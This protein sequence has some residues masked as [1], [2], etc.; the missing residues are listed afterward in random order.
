V[1]AD[2]L[3]RRILE[4]GEEMVGS[5][6]W[7]GGAGRLMPDT[8]QINLR[9]QW[10]HDNDFARWIRG[11]GPEPGPTATMDCREALMHIAHR[12][13]AVDRSRL[14]E[15]HAQARLK[16]L[17]VMRNTGSRRAAEAAHS[18]VISDYLGPGE[19]TRYRIDRITGTGGPD[20]PAGH[21]V[22]AGG[23]SH[24][25]LSL[26]TRDALGR[27]EVLSHWVY[28]GH[29]PAG[30]LTRHSVGVLQKTSVE[31]VLTTGGL[32]RTW[33]ESALPSWLIS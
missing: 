27:Q 24:V 28:P 22:F 13:G 7:R 14:L 6:R 11:L 33:V 31:E 32:D 2:A 19:R 26:G 17:S 15:V 10:G 20:I 16:A 8:W 9:T 12:A 25:M 3:S 29:T 1:I 30:P 23:M 4:T 21:V 5:L 18:K